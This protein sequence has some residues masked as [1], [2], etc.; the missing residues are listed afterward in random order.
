MKIRLTNG[1]LLVGGV[2]FTFLGFVWDSLMPHF[3]FGWC[4]GQVLL[5]YFEQPKQRVQK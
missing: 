2:L 3:L 5:N 4:F 1:A